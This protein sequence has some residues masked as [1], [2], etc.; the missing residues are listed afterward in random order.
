MNKY[1]IEI[2]ERMLRCSFG[3]W[4]HI[5]ALEQ[6]AE[7]MQAAIRMALPYIG[8]ERTDDAEAVLRTAIR[9]V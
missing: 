7:Q 6:D 1:N 3:L 5:E 2:L 4:Q 8:S 9:D